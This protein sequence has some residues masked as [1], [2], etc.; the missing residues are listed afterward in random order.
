MFP[1]NLNTEGNQRIQTTIDV[2]LTYI[3]FDPTVI[4]AAPYYVI[5]LPYDILVKLYN[6]IFFS[7]NNKVLQQY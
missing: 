2:F 5:N 6:G 3:G 1:N 7:R 4:V